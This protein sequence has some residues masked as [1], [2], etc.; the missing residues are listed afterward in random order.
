VHVP[1]RGR[2]H[3]GRII[4]CRRPWDRLVRSYDGLRDSRRRVKHILMGVI[5]VVVVVVGVLVLVRVLTVELLL[6][7]LEE[8]VRPR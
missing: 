5:R 4:I 8:K 2:D 3:R 1:P 6:G 7:T